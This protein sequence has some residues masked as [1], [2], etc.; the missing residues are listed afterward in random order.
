MLGTVAGGREEWGDMDLVLSSCGLQCNEDRQMTD[1][2]HIQENWRDGQVTYTTLKQSNGD[3]QGAGLDSTVR[4][5][6][7]CDHGNET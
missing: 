1:N 5:D 3:G 6:T 7:K 2:K 4:K